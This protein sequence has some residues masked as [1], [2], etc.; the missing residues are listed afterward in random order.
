MANDQSFYLVKCLFIDAP[1]I[2]FSINVTNQ[3]CLEANLKQ[4]NQGWIEIFWNISNSFY[5]SL[6]EQSTVKN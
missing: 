5:V 1:L 4:K 6:G 3:N 2:W